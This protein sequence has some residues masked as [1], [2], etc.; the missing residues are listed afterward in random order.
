M[1]NGQQVAPGA[2]AT[3]TFTAALDADKASGQLV[4]V[5]TDAD[6]RQT[7]SERAPYSLQDAQVKAAPNAPECARAVA[8]RG[9]LYVAALLD[10]STQ[11]ARLSPFCDLHKQ[12]VH[13]SI[14]S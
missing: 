1:H 5:V 9:R 3:C 2:S 7:E 13:T 12:P 6:G 4:A 10:F 8:V 14:S 11:R